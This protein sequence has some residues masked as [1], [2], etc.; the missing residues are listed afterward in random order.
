MYKIILT[1]ILVVLISGCKSDQSLHTKSDST[2]QELEKSISPDNKGTTCGTSSYKVDF[3]PENKSP[4]GWEKVSLK[5]SKEQHAIT[6]HY[7]YVHFEIEC[8]KNP[9]GEKFIVY[10]AYCSGSACQDFDNWGIISSDSLEI[11]LEP[12]GGNHNKA[13]E[14]FGG[15]LKPF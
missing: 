6:R 8:L 11:L 5:V 15:K 12:T 14:I 9:D 10:Q 2:H 1:S 13:E 3:S 4:W 7:E